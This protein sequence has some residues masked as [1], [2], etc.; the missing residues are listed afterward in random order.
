LT[1]SFIKP[2]CFGYNGSL[3]FS[4]TSNHT[5]LSYTV[6]GV[7]ATS[8]VSVPAG[9]H[10]VRV[11]D[12]DGCYQS[13]S[14][15]ISQPNKL[16]IAYELKDSSC[17]GSTRASV[18]MTATGGNEPYYF[19]LLSGEQNFEG[20]E[21]F[22]LTESEY[23]LMVRDSK[24]CSDQ[25]VLYIYEPAQ[26]LTNY[27]YSN[28]TCIG[29]NDGTIELAVSGGTE[30]YLFYVG[31]QVSDT[32]L[33]ENL[34]EGVWDVE[35]VD[36]NGCSVIINSISLSDIQAECLSIPNA[37]TPNDDGIND[38]WIIENLDIYTQAQVLVFNRWGQIIYNEDCNHLWDG[39]YNERF[40]PAGT[41]VYIVNLNDGTEARVGL[42]SV[43]Y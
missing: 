17:Y 38:I 18:K 35:V 5:P 20:E 23:T 15:S 22:N 9:N 31:N 24:N 12:S 30:P 6:N 34:E 39:K 28:P 10:T 21:H 25:D 11:T 8:P 19:T 43:V 3:S 33:I 37:F 32:S 7:S 4:S 26:I 1:T 27:V 14:V 16:T 41:Y 13:K 40:V 2:D 42:V 36:T 29:N